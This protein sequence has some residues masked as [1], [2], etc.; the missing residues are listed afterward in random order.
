MPDA[1]PRISVCIVCRN[2]ADKLPPFARQ[3][4]CVV[5]FVVTLCNENGPLDA[6]AE[7]MFPP[8]N[9]AAMTATAITLE[10]AREG[11]DTRPDM[12]SPQ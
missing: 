5:E 3:M 4:T 12:R 1:G 7:E 6:P 11:A 2:E 10:S 9:I 8:T